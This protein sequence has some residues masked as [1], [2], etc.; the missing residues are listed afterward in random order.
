MGANE[1]RVELANC[2]GYF[3]FLLLVRNVNPVPGEIENSRV[4][5]HAQRER[6]KSTETEMQ[7]NHT[8]GVT[9]WTGC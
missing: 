3:V 1:V 2:G 4:E 7:R 6:A 8:A 5:P 9:D